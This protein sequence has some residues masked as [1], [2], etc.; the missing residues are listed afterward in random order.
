MLKTLTRIVRKAYGD[1]RKIDPVNHPYAKATTPD[2]L[3]TATVIQSFAKEFDDWTAK[4]MWEGKDRAPSKENRRLDHDEL[5]KIK[6]VLVNTKRGIT[7]SWPVDR[8]CDFNYGAGTIWYK[9]IHQSK[10]SVNGVEINGVC[11]LEI[12]NSWFKLSKQVAEAKAAAAA[13]LKRQKLEEKKWNLAENLLGMK[14]NEH[15]ALVPVNP[16]IDEQATPA[17]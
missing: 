1:D 13:A 11:S 4:D 2:Q 15:G 16:V 10:G 14:R 8:N 3:I 12:F 9:Y 7:V 17:T 6:P 5:A